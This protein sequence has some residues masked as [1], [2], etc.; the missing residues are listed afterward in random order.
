MAR[1]IPRRRLGAPQPQ[2]LEA[3][4]RRALR[5]MI[6][7]VRATLPQVTT[8][9]KAKAV[10]AALRKAWPASRIRKILEEH[11]RKG[12]RAGSKAW[13]RRV[14]KD[15]KLQRLDAVEFDGEA[16]VRTWS[17]EALKII[18]SVRDEVAAGLQAD[19]VEAAL[20][21]T[22]PS[23]LAARWVAKGI[24]VEFGTLEGRMKVIAQNQMARLHAEVQKTR[25]TAFGVTEFVWR[26]QRDK[27]VRPEH[28]GIADKTFT[29]AKGHSKEGRPGHKPGCRCWAESIIP[30]D[31]EF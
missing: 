15:G 9:A 1:K 5:P 11:G 7:S 29:Y 23:E 2:A 14:R 22:D 25:A 20:A 21:G 13:Q 17:N 24:P 4:L 16:L 27:D 26:T 8:A 6:A 28:R 31:F 10:G 30:D 12:E 19:I 3:A 18:V